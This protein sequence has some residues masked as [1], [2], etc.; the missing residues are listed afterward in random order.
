MGALDLCL[1]CKGCK[2]E[3]PVNVD[4]ATYKAEFLSH[5]YRGRVRPKA[6]YTLGLIHRW[7]RLASRAPRLVNAVTHAPLLGS[8]LKRLGGVAPQRQAPRFAH[9]TF[10][11]WFEA[12]PVRG[13]GRPQVLLWPDT[14]TNYLRPE[15]GKAHVEVLEDAGFQVVLPERVLCCGRP[16]YDYGM[17]DT[18]ERLLRTTIETL[19]P[20][21]RAGT[22][23]IGM[24]PSCV[25]VFRDELTELLP[26]DLDA[27][28]LQ[29]QTLMLSE[30]LADRVPSWEPPQ[31]DRKALVQRHCHHGAVMGFDPEEE[32]LRKIG[33]DLS[34]PNPGCCGLAGSFG[35]EAGRK[36]AVSMAVGEQALLPAVRKEPRDTIVVADGFSCRTQIEHGTGRRAMHL[37]EVIRLAQRAAAGS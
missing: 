8:L 9:Q 19:R 18:A 35:F 37:A 11:S 3:C 14:F 23:L 24:E 26:D 10:R 32:L 20:H 12:R 2:S 21:I 13:A 25:A 29:K 28:R 15:T 27:E 34:F 6:A 4:M 33:L 22:P 31:L 1:S 30:F 16:L 7:A 36:Y 17:L 5:H